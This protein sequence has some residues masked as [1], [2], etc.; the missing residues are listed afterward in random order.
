[1]TGRIWDQFLTERD[2]AVFKAAGYTASVG[3]GR[4]P[5]VLVIDVAY[6]FCGDKPEPILESIKRW[7]RSCGEESWEAIARIRSVLDQARQVGVP[8][9]YSTGGFREDKWD[10]GSW[11]WK[12][13]RWS[14]DPQ[15]T[16]GL[17][18]QQIMPEIA[19]QPQDLVVFKQKPS[20]F[21]STGLLSYLVMLGCDSV[22]IMGTSTSGCV[23]ATAID[24]FSNN[25]RTAVV[26]D[27]CFDRSQASHAVTLCDL[28]AK[29]ADVVRADETIDFLRTIEPGSFEL[30]GGGKGPGR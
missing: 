12:S 14:E 3:F 4:R 23:R 2:K 10:M 21:F 11:R 19:P 26:E 28:N 20:A 25:F 13:A 30:P 15:E 6:A 27:G 5:A 9:I 1:M 16:S 7:R 29:Y 17:D 24:A 18:E 8:V 22:I